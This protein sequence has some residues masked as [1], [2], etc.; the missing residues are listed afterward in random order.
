MDDLVTRAI[1]PVAAHPAVTGVAFAGSRSRGT[2]IRRDALEQEF[3]I[4][5]SRALE[6]EVLAGNRRARLGG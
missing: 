3:G 1:R 4:S 2:V 5:L 6:H